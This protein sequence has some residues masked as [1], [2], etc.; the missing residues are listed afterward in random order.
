MKAHLMYRDQDFAPQASLPPHEAELT[1][2]L[3]LNTLFDAM[4]AGD[5]FLLEA[6]RKAVLTS[7]HE[8]AA[9]DYR[10][11]V[12]AD[13]L[14]RPAIRELKRVGRRRAMLRIARSLWPWARR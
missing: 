12:L 6:A 7:L 10:Q 3:E 13:C 9:I 1:Q 8:P 2:D 11:H 5:E 14:D 4:A